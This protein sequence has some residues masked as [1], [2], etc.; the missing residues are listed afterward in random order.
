MRL[1]LQV[2][3]FKMIRNMMQTAIMGKTKKAV[4]VLQKWSR[5]LWVNQF[6]KHTKSIFWHKWS[7]TVIWG[8]NHCHRPFSL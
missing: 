7:H 2:L 5:F 8:S 1:K 4:Q 3:L 6:Q